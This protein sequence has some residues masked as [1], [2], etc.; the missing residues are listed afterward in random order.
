MSYRLPGIIAGETTPSGDAM[1]KECAENSGKLADI[2][3]GMHA[4][5]RKYMAE[6]R[7]AIWPLAD[8]Y[9]QQA[10][11]TSCTVT[12]FSKNLLEVKSILAI[13]PGTT[14][15]LTLGGRVMTIT[16]PLAGQP[17]AIPDMHLILRFGDVRQLSSATNGYY[18][19]ELMGEYHA[20][21]YSW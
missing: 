14:A 15:T 12:P 8:E 17:L 20:D 18:F 16:S 10:A 4:D 6:S 3:L 13:F 19:L 9:G 7:R 1:C 2:L 11:G 21:Q 5:F